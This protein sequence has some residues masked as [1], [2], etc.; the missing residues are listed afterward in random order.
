MH[1]SYPKGT[2]IW[3]K[4]KSGE[5]IVGKFFDHKSGKVLIENGPIVNLKEVRS[6][7]ARKIKADII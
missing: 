6:M 5:I 3:I 4:M 2:T 1:T 7:S